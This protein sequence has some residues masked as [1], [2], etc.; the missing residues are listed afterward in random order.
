MN[1]SRTGVGHQVRHVLFGKFIVHVRSRYM[2]GCRMSLSVKYKRFTIIRIRLTILPC[3]PYNNH[4]D[5]STQR[6]GAVILK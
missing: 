3:I 5:Y 2:S 4:N 1:Y 6:K